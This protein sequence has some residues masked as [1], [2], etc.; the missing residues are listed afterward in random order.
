MNE[1]RSILRREIETHGP[2]TFARFMEIALY[3]PDLG[4]YEQ[5]GNLPG[6]SSHFYTSVNVGSIFGEL[7]AFQFAQWFENSTQVQIVEA[8]AGDGQLALNLLISLHQ[9]PQSIA[10]VQYHILEPS[11]RLQKIQR[12]CLKEFSRQIHW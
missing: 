6:K 1:V 10:E 4:F 5:S 11:L 9:Y 2:L 7:L 3:R 8:G 12:S